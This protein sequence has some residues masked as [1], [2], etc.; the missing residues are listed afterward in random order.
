MRLYFSRKDRRRNFPAE[1][2][3]LDAIVIVTIGRVNF[4][5]RIF[6]PRDRP[7]FSPPCRL[8][9]CRT[10][11]TPDV[12]FC[13]CEMKMCTGSRMLAQ[14]RSSPRS[15]RAAPVQRRQLFHNVDCDRRRGSTQTHSGQFPTGNVSDVE[16]GL[17]ARPPL[18]II[19]VSGRAVAHCVRLQH[20]VQWPKL[21]GYTYL[22][23]ARA[24]FRR[25]EKRGSETLDENYGA[26]DDPSLSSA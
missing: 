1:L 4:A 17:R 22:Q 12:L 18:C 9:R 7:P 13:R 11:A 16:I 26:N 20:T 3:P 5:E 6:A 21:P 23:C 2:A 15:L 10:S 19:S 8:P 24:L 14:S 25:G